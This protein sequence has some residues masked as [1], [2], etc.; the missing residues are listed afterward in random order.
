MLNIE[1]FIRRARA[2]GLSESTIRYNVSVLNRFSKF[3]EEKHIDSITRSS[4]IDFISSLNT[5][6]SSI[7]TYLDAIRRYCELM[8]IDVDL[9]GIIKRAQAYVVRRTDSLTVDE[10]KSIINE[11]TY[12][13]KLIY[14]LMYVYARRLGEVLGATVNGDLI[15]F[16]ILKQKPRSTV[17]YPL[18]PELTRMINEC[19]ALGKCGKDKLFNVTARAVELHFKRVSLKLINP[20]GRRLKPHIL[21]SSRVTHLVESGIPLDEVVKVLTKH[22][23]IN[24][25]YQYYLSESNVNDVINKVNVLS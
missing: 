13:Y 21:R 18:T 11:S 25:A 17:S 9:R 8:D 23:N 14:A 3:M 22:R 19:I 10:V 12:P 5:S 2:V 15:V 24:I 20:N 7:P 6:K 1:E 16:P 4:I